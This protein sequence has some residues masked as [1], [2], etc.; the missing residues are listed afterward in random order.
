[1]YVAHFSHEIKI[2]ALSCVG[3]F[4][5]VHFLFTLERGRVRW[6][7]QA[8]PKRQRQEVTGTSWLNAILRRITSALRNERHPLAAHL[9][10]FNVSI[11]AWGPFT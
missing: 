2:I 1:M 10:L 11:R 9:R 7:A 3:K 4:Y 6:F 5:Q 8:P